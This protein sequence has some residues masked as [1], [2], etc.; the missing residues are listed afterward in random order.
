MKSG[1]LDW[2]RLLCSERRK[3]PATNVQQPQ[4]PQFVQE[5]RHEAERD[6]DRILFSTPTRRLADKTQVFPL[7]PNDSV[8]TRLTHSHEVSNLARSIGTSL[9]PDIQ[10]ASG[11][12]DAHRDVPARLAAVGLAHDLG[13]P[14]FGHKGEAAI[15][16]WVR[17]NKDRL[18][19][20]SEE[21]S[22][23]MKSDLAKMTPAL[24]QDFLAFEGNAQTFRVLT[25]LQVVNDARGL[26]LTFGTLA[27]LMKYTV[28]SEVSPLKWSIPRYGFLKEDHNG[29][30]AYG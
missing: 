9:A 27:A 23:E 20:I 13:N 21:M 7:E 24:Q 14:P 19:S 22:D 8:R 5:T 17:K 1:Q 16:D 10:K 28:S 6:Y 18:F 2:K 29:K 12:A 26:N 4:Q 15:Q 25:K 30:E 3:G 11:L